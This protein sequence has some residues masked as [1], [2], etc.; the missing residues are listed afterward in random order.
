MRSVA[1]VCFPG[2][3]P[4]DVAGPHEVLAGANQANDHLNGTGPIYDIELLAAEPGPVSGES[5]LTIVAPNGLPTD[6]RWDTILVPGGEGSRPARGAASP[7]DPLVRWLAEHGPLARRVATVCTGTFLAAAAGLCQGRRVTT[8][9]NNAAELAAAHPECTVDPDP[10]YVRDGDLWTSAGVTAGIDLAL[11]LVEQDCGSAV[12][13]LVARHLVVYLR[14][15]GGQSQ[16]ASAV[17]A[18]PTELAPI[19]AAC[20]AIHHSPAD[21]LSVDALAHRV[22]L[23]ARHLTRL[24]QAELGEPPARYVERVRVEAARTIL[25]RESVCLDQV[26]ERCGFG[27][28]ETLRRAFHRRLGIS[29]AAYRR[30]SVAVRPPADVIDQRP[31]GQSSI[32][33]PTPQ[34]TPEFITEFIPE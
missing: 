4:L 18:E 25:E 27:T 17:W 15:P 2:I 22:G 21:D 9:W 20:D 34:H 31:T 6:R 14:R 16:F 32:D 7:D 28:A 11:A 12:A 13:Q 23:S 26:A 33:P 3:Q 30:Q 10:I 5:G 1:I 19:R 24:F 8:H 29:P